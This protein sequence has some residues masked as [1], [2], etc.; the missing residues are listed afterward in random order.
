M[1]MSFDMI[2]NMSMTN[3]NPINTAPRTKV[4]YTKSFNIY[5]R[6]HFHKVKTLGIII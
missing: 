2:M 6:S 4:C 3:P 5:F 1:K